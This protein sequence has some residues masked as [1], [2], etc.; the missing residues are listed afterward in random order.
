MTTKEESLMEKIKN[1]KIPRA[2]KKDAKYEGVSFQGERERKKN[3]LLARNT[4]NTFPFPLDHPT[5]PHAFFF[6]FF[7]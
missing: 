6:S 2:R 5:F 7:S 4:P 3:A 1:Q